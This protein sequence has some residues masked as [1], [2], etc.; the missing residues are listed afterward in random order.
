MTLEDFN[1]SQTKRRHFK[2][3]IKNETTYEFIKKIM[4]AYKDVSPKHYETFRRIVLLYNLHNIN[5]PGLFVDDLTEYFKEATGTGWMDMVEETLV[6]HK[7][8]TTYR[9][10]IKFLDP[11]RT[12][13]NTFEIELLKFINNS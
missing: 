4:K 6:Y 3:E 1:Q 7:Y 10:P 11:N 2:L 13:R 9:F 12:D 5:N 8:E